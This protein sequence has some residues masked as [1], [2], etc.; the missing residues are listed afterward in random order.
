[1]IIVAKCGS[2]GIPL[3]WNLLDNKSGN[4]NWNDRWELLEKII[5]VIGKDR[6]NMIVGD[7]EFIGI[8]WIKYLITSGI[9]FCMR[10]PKS[11]LFTLGNNEI[12]SI[13]QLLESS[14]E[15][16]FQECMVDGVW[17]NVMLKKASKRRV[18]ILNR[19][20]ASKKFGQKLQKT[21]VNRMGRPV[22]YCFR[23][24]KIEVSTWKALILNVTIN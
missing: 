5:N 7:R 23:T 20:P 22:P 13:E 16:Y 11:Q 24:S 1:L 3:Y 4:S 18:F 19:E 17:C 2:I 12:F 9:I 8:N 10:V 14:E 6:I 21:V 15:R